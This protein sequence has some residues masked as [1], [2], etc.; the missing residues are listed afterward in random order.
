MHKRLSWLGAVLSAVVV[1]FVASIVTNAG[2]PQPR[3]AGDEASLATASPTSPPNCDEFCTEE[4]ACED[5]CRYG[6]DITCGEYAQYAQG[7]TC[8]SCGSACNAYVSCDLQCLEQGLRTCGETQYGCGSAPENCSSVCHEPSVYCSTAC[9]DGSST[10]TC[11]ARGYRRD[12]PCYQSASDYSGV[13]EPYYPWWDPELQEWVTDCYVWIA[14]FQYD[15]CQSGP[16]EDLWC[17]MMLVGAD[18]PPG[19]CCETY[20]SIYGCNNVYGC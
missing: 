10:T 12:E 18:Q 8:V 13:F 7:A 3:A 2:A 19:T 15:P 11:G 6:T 14:N 5:A 1:V 9:W 16:I 17:S 20:G 4:T